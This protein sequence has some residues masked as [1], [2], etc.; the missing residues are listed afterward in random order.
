MDY[1]II[2]VILVLIFFIFDNAVIF[3]SLKEKNNSTDYNLGLYK[4]YGALKVTVLKIVLLSFS[5]DALFNPV[6]RSAPLI[7][8]GLYFIMVTMSVFRSFKRRN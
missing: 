6:G 3:R 8:I 5:I 1:K 7:I 4:K 2:T